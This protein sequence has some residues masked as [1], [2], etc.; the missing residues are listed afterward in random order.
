MNPEDPFFAFPLLPVAP[1]DA[2]VTRRSEASMVELRDGSVLLAYSRH[3]GSS[4]DNAKGSIVG[5]LLDEEA[6]PIT[7][8]RELV[9][10]PEN[11]FNVMSPAL[12]R[13]PDG[14][15]GMLFSHR[16][17]QQEASR[18][19]TASSDEGAT[20]CEPVIVGE[21]AYKTG[22]HDRFTVHSSGRLIAPL[23]CTED[24]DSW[25]L[26]VQVA[27]SDDLGKTWHLSDKLELPRVHWPEGSG[28]PPL[29]SGCIEPGTVE[30][31]DGSLLM[32]IRT[33]MG[34]QFCSESFDRGTTWTS[35]RSMEVISP[36]AP[37][38]L[39]RIPGTDD[40]LLLWTPVYDAKADVGFSG[41]RTTIMAC[42]SSDGG[43][44]WPPARRKI[45][46]RDLSR[47]V[48]YPTILY[49]GKET[50]VTL[51]SASG[52]GVLEGCTSTS[53]MKVPLAWFYE[54]P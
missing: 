10:A 43:R 45:L 31:A 48:D 15:I 24:R 53:L 34:T 36:I 22:C 30:R 28:G 35:P 6:R 13:L 21:G 3:L 20:W 18:R 11:G 42:V 25:H 52:R 46:A 5:L 41:A 51:R 39:S 29:E 37:A 17:S 7:E 2:A 47:S 26:Y 32:T 44:S 23:H 49:R 14:R 50:W 4:N 9:P 40:L 19:F 1:A 27:R 38:H 12:R 8:E 54:T 16:V 33:A